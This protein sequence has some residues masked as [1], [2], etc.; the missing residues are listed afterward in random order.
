MRGR[1]IKGVGGLYTV[2]VDG[3]TYEGK[4]RGI[5]RNTNTKVLIGDWVNCTIIDEVTEEIVIEEIMERSNELVRPKVCNVDQVIIVF[6]LKSPNINYDLLDRFIVLAEEVGLD[7]II[8]INKVDLLT[9]EE[10]NAFNDIYAK[11]YKVIFVSTYDSVGIEPI[12]NMLNGKV[13]VLAGPSGVGKSSIINEV[14][15]KNTMD[16]GEISDKIKRGKHTTRHSEFIPI[17]FCDANSFLVDSPGFTSL[18]FGHL[19]AT[20]LK[21]YFKEF[22]EF[23]NCK[24]QNC[25]HINEPDCEVKEHIGKEIKE[26]RYNRYKNFYNEILNNRR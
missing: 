5:F 8:C 16:T 23:S 13:T 22:R 25:N 15:Q 12:K 26:V 7:I 20:E 10:I 1:V 4:P 19:D 17:P 18:F 2:Y 21:Y 11:L 3:K 9:E 6:A 24:Y 14:L